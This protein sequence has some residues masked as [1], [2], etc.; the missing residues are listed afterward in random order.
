[1]GRTPYLLFDPMSNRTRTTSDTVGILRAAAYL[2]GIGVRADEVFGEV[3][4][5]SEKV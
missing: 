1:M 5:A 2:D 3:G 4:S